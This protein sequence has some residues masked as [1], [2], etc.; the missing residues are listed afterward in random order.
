MYLFMIGKLTNEIWTQESN[1]EEERGM[2]NGKRGVQL[3]LLLMN[4]LIFLFLHDIKVFESIRIQAF[5]I[6][7][8]TC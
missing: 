2:K 7:F 3:D 1:S 6:R 5:E 8:R 4:C